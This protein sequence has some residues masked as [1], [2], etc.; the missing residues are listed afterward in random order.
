MRNVKQAKERR[1]KG[2]KI[3]RNG[4]MED[5]MEFTAPL[6][7]IHARFLWIGPLPLAQ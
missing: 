3:L 6:E 2:K 1:Q 7:E 4:K 5:G